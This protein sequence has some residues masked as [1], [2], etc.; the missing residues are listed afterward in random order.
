V[1]TEVPSKGVAGTANIAKQGEHVAVA[2]GGAIVPCR[3]PT[4]FPLREI[5]PCIV[6]LSK[7]ENGEIILQI[8][9]HAEATATTGPSLSCHHWCVA[10]KCMQII[11]AAL[12]D[13][14]HFYMFA[15]FEGFHRSS[16]MDSWAARAHG[17]ER[18]TADRA[19]FPHAPQA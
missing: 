10:E 17:M 7:G 19:W 1:P 4:V 11:L 16:R 12:G 18:C 6:G 8:A 5:E 9:V 13:V 15:V 2:R 14:V 3:R